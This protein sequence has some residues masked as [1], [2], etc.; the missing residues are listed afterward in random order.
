MTQRDES[1][2]PEELDSLFAAACQQERGPEAETPLV[3]DA[4]LAQ[5]LADALAL[6]PDPTPTRAAKPPVWQSARA[7]LGG[8]LGLGGVA[9][10]GMAGLAVG[11]GA[12]ELLS[13]GLT[14]L[15]Q[16]AG[17]D[18]MLDPLDG[19]AVLSLLEEGGA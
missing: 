1:L 2:R 7:A 3:S 4:L 11:L 19:Y 15:A 5:V 8:W 9:L 13:T 6:Q 17:A 12:P 18:L 10:A 14:T 16:G